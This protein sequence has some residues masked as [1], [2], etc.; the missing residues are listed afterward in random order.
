M[1]Y[2]ITGR[3]G[4]GKTTLAY[5]ISKQVDG[6]VIDGDEIRKYFKSDF[7]DEGRLSN[8][9]TMAWIAK[10]L[11]KQGKV[12]IVACISPKR[13]WRKKVQLMFNN[14][15]EICMPFGTLWKGTEYEEPE[16]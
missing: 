6:I 11:E 7:T 8:I 15:I 13:E 10:I 5:R 2:W 16:K 3:K 4:S 12:V 14:C 9:Y 1:V